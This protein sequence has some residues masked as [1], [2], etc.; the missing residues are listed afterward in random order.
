MTIQ[1]RT[2]TGLAGARFLYRAD[3]LVTHRQF[4]PPR[5][6]WGNASQNVSV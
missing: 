1:D 4:S 2:G 6:R 5:R 3:L